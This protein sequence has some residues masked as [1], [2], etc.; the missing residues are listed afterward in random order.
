[1]AGEKWMWH[2]KASGN[3]S[4]RLA[5]RLNHASTPNHTEIGQIS[6]STRNGREGNIL[7]EMRSLGRNS[8][9]D[10]LDDLGGRRDYAAAT[11]A[12]AWKH[13]LVP[14]PCRT[15]WKRRSPTIRKW[16]R[17]QPKRASWRKI[18]SHRRQKT[19][20]PWLARTR[21]LSLRHRRRLPSA[22]LIFA[23][24][25]QA[26]C[27]VNARANSSGL[28]TKMHDFGIRRVSKVQHF[29]TRRGSNQF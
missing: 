14:L 17:R 8:P 18:S 4:I 11:L 29:G 27:F 3:V 28:S 1:M 12:F 13:F 25:V 6:S 16:R 15:C 7:W 9:P 22:L 19:S 24:W 10:V 23:F 20:S 5:L 2:T 21:T 26:A